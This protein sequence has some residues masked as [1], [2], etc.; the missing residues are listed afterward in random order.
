MLGPMAGQ[1]RARK[2]IQHMQ[3]GGREESRLRQRGIMLLPKETDARDRK[4]PS[5]QQF[6]GDTQINRNWLT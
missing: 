5:K 3:K 1:N 4:L 6:H 2:E